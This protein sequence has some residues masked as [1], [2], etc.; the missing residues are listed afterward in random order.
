M[1]GNTALLK[2]SSNV[3]GC[4]LAIEKIFSRQAGFPENAFRTLLVPGSETKDII[5]NPKVAAV[6]LT[7]STPAGK[8]DRRGGR[9]EA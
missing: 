9:R 2:H 6:T 8:S 5:Q 3:S 1:A 4:A 7:G